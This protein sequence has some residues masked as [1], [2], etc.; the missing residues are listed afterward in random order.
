M[1]YREVVSEI[2]RSVFKTLG[3]GF[4]KEVYQNALRIAFEKNNLMYGTRIVP[5]N[6]E[7]QTI[8]TLTIAVIQYRVCI[9]VDTKNFNECIT[10]C[11]NATRLTQLPYGMVCIFPSTLQEELIIHF[12]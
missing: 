6:Y 10:K 1:N 7:N 3:H 9:V 8:G 2:A 5:I 11:S 4:E 12:V